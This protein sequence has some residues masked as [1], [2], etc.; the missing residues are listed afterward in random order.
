MNK[1][2]AKSFILATYIC[3]YRAKKYLYF[4][5]MEGNDDERKTLANLT[6]DHELN[7]PSLIFHIDLGILKH[8]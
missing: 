6:N 2:V 3:S 7:Y 4:Y 8:N 1:S 5:C